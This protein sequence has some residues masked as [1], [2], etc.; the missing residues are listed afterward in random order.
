MGKIVDNQ[1]DASFPELSIEW[2]ASMGTFDI[3]RVNDLC[4]KKCCSN[5]FKAGE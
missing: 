1:L 5:V 4:I 3:L 2:P